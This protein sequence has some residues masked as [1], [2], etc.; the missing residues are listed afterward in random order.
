[1]NKRLIPLIPALFLAVAGC[2]GEDDT[3]GDGGDLMDLTDVT[4]TW[5]LNWSCEQGPDTI[6]G[7]DIGRI[8]DQGK[9]D[10][11]GHPILGVDWS[12][13]RG[14]GVLRANA[15]STSFQHG[16]QGAPG[17]YIENAVYTFDRANPDIFRK[18]SV[19]SGA[20][21]SGFCGGVGKKVP[22]GQADC[23]P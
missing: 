7:C 23:Q 12:G 5:Q 2:L 18:E 6:T 19:Y 11:D 20:D 3:E 15:L 4:G 9:K 8:Y 21:V 1:M 13:E 22:D 16:A 17:S 14:D 10:P